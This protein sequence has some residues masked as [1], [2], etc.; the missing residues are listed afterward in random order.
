MDEQLMTRRELL[1]HATE[2]G[3]LAA[4]RMLLPAFAWSSGAVALAA[5]AAG[6]SRRREFDLAIQETPFDLLGR[7][8]GALSV[9]GTIPGPLLRMREGDEVLLRVRNALG[10]DAS[11]HWHG[12]L[13]PPEMDGVPGLSFAGIAP[14]ATFPYR[15]PVKQYGTYWYHSHSGGQEQQGVYGPLVID[16]IAPEPYRYERDH[17]VM[18]SEWSDM[19]PMTLMAKLKKESGY[20]NFQRRTIGDFFADISRMGLGGAFAERAMWAQM[21]MDPTDIAD[22]TGNVYTYLC[23]GR[24]AAAPWT[25]AFKPGERVRLRF[26]D[27]GAMTIFDVRIPGLK[28]TV[29]Q[30]DGQDIRPVVVDELRIA[31]GETYDVIVEPTED[32]AYAVFAETMDRSGFAIGTLAPRP[33]MQAPV[34]ERRRRPLRTMADM[35]MDHGAGAG[36]GGMDHGGGGGTSGHEGHPMP[37]PRPSAAGH[38][39]HGTPSASPS[40]GASPAAGGHGGHGAAPAGGAVPHGPD[41]HGPGNQ[42][43]PAATKP[44]IHEPG[45][46]L[47]ED[48]RRVLVY[49]DLIALRPDDD[50]RP[51]VREIELHL[52]GHMERFIWSIDGQ[53][54]SDAPAPIVFRAG[55]R[56]RLT[57]VNDTM[58][59]HPMHLHGMWMYLEGG[60]GE[61][62]TMPRK[63]TI[64]VKPAERLSVAITADAPP[65]L[66]AFHCHMLLHMEAGMFRAVQVVA[67]HTEGH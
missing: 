18:L 38:E 19:H 6:A 32:R 50:A 2:I 17:V 7:K 64:I 46:G 10:E 33:G 60:R 41:N 66:W 9:N 25:G 22:V 63:H 13:L 37:T 45:T 12:L 30:A 27:A 44:R 54:Y 61:G 52:T 36:H 16:P 56:L 26:I 47:G 43:V 8:R 28:M 1:A 53:K 59:E 31:P 20:F 48:G 55:E 57:M 42:M 15:F 39:G 34:P 11:I 21:R 49:A 51:P 4:A 3:L 35:G 65:G 23:N 24:P 40:P 62:R 67:S 58:M 14:G 29:V 5:P